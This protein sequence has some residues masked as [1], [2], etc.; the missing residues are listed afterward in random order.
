ML[1]IESSLVKVKHINTRNEK[2]G[3]DNVLG[4]DLR[5]QAR[6]SNDVLSLFSPTLKSSFFHKDEAVQGDLVT[7]AGY[8][9]NLKNPNIGAIKWTGDWENQRLVVHNGVREE[10]DIILTDCKVNKLSFELQEGGTVFVAFRVQAHPDEVTTA[11]LLSLLGT[12]VHM[13]LSWDEPAET[14]L[15]A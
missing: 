6:M 13:S 5:L 11:K 10:F 12:E 9:P 3:D 4:V 1:E 2:H 14:D 15:A 8:L 7:D